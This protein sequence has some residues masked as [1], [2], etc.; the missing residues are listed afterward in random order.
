MA[1]RVTTSACTVAPIVVAS[2]TIAA[3]RKI[4]R[5]LAKASAPP[6]NRLMSVAPNSAVTVLPIA[7]GIDA[8]NFSGRDKADEERAQHNGR[9]YWPSEQ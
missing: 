2:A 8:S 6:A 3:K 1:G 4:R 7:I 9:P 5:G